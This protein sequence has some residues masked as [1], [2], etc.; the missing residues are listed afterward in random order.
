M[1]IDPIDGTIE[2][3]WGGRE[4]N[5]WNRYVITDPLQEKTRDI[6]ISLEQAAPEIFAWIAGS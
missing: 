4:E 3:C 1:I 6:Q 5:G 2:L